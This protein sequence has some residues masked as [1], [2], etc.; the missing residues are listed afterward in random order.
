MRPTASA[1][2]L[3]MSQKARHNLIV[4]VTILVLGGMLLMSLLFSILA[5]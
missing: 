1:K 4:A 2:G 5:W 3:P